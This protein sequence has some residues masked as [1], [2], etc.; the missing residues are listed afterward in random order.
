VKL[1]GDQLK[2]AVL[3]EFKKPLVLED[4]AQPEAGPGEVLIKVEACG[5]CHSDLHVADGDWPQFSRITKKPL[6]PGHEIAGR[7]VALGETVRDLSIGDH[8]GVPWIY[9]TCGE[10]EACREGN[11]NLCS[12]QQIT[13]VSVD[14][15]YADFMKARASHTQI[16]PTGLSSVEAAPLFCA[17]VTVYRALH[18]TKIV[19]GQRLAVFGV[20]GLGQVAVQIG[21]CL[22]AEVTAVDVSDE[23]LATAKALGAF[24]TLNASATNVVKEFRSIGGAHIAIVT[25]AAKAAYDTAFSCLRSR[26][27]LLVVGLPSENICFPP[28]MMAAGE[29]HIQASA[30]G[31]RKDL[32]EV[33]VMAS[34]G[35]LRCQVAARPLAQ[36]N[37]VL[38]ELRRG[39][40]AGRVVLTPV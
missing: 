32:R 5:V 26:G 31:T 18:Q 13:G 22:E 27:T 38:E 10:C 4:V 40:I 17:G 21:A 20:G 6:I 16:I 3:H 11:E 29:V 28:I 8:V 14:G 1:L 19:P 39:K 36:V 7:I 37:E 12:K 34:N 33:L 2:A 23:K 35:K 30:V 15:G 25:S 24:R 9:W